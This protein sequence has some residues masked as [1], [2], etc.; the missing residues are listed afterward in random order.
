MA[1]IFVGY[2][3]PDDKRAIAIA[4]ADDLAPNYIGKLF[5]QEEYDI[6]L[7]LGMKKRVLDRF[8][9]EGALAVAKRLLND[10]N[11]G[12]AVVAAHAVADASLED[13]DA[14]IVL[15]SDLP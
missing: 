8:A 2:N 15:D 11:V 14:A 7:T 4:V 6:G 1:D 3:V 13:F 12:P 9:L 5:T 10:A